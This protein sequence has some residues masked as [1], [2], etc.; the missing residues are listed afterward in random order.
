MKRGYWLALTA[1]VLILG[2]AGYRCSTE[3]VCELQAVSDAIRD[4][5][6][7]YFIDSSGDRT[8]LFMTDEKGTIYGQIEAPRLQGDW[9]N[10]YGS[11]VKDLDGQ[12]YV[13]CYS[14]SLT[15]LSVHSVVYRCDFENSALVPVYTLPDQRFYQIQVIDGW[16]YYFGEVG[17]GEGTWGICRMS[18]EGSQELFMEFE[19]DVSSVR[20]SFCHPDKGTVWTDSSSRFYYDGRDVTP[21]GKRDYVN[22]QVD[23][24]GICYTDV[25]EGTVKRVSFEDLHPEILFYTED[26]RLIEGG[27]D[28]MDIVPFRYYED[29]SWTGGVDITPERRVLGVFEK[30]G[31]Q[32]LQISR[33]ILSPAESFAL[34][35]NTLCICLAALM[36]LAGATK[37]GLWLTKG[38][39]PVIF[40]LLLFLIPL[41]IITSL[42]L[43][44]RISHFV[45]ERMLR[46]QYGLLY[47]SVEWILN[48]IDPEDLASIELQ[49]I[50]EDPYYKKVFLSE[51][52]YEPESGQAGVQGNIQSDLSNV[53]VWLL[54]KQEGALRYALTDENNYY[55]SRISYDRTREELEKME[56]AMDTGQIIQT[57]YNDLTG[58]FIALYVPVLDKEGKGIGIWECGLST[59]V[60][61]YEQAQQTARIHAMLNGSMAVLFFIMLVVLAFFIYPLIRLKAAV[62]SVSQGNL[63]LEVRVRGRDEV[64]GIGNA[65]NNMSRQ[66]KEHV[67]F[68]QACLEGYA[69]F[70]PEKV[71]E[72]LERKDIT[73]VRLGDQK[74]I[75]GAVLNLGSVQFEENARTMGGDELY[76]LINQMLK[77]MIPAVAEN[78]GI[79]ERMEEDGLNAYYPEACEPALNSAI[80]I[81]QRFRTLRTEGHRMPVYRANI[82]YGRLR[83]GIVGSRERMA[84]AV[85][86]DLIGITSF[87]KKMGETYGV[88][89]LVLESAAAQIPDFKKRFHVR[90]IGTLYR[91]RTGEA[92]YVYDVYNGDEAEDFRAKEKTKTKFEKAMAAYR[93]GRYYD[94]RL[95]FAKILKE[96]GRDLAAREYVYR[97]D[98]YCQLGEKAAVRIHLEEY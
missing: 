27:L 98:Q 83:L 86:S 2:I 73:E 63:G 49:N 51:D 11:L 60:L 89:I 15:E 72:L 4:G 75:L 52:Y 30:D 57:K 16:V 90:E 65:F 87:L 17:E 84:A 71:F 70:V 32:R 29:G 79:V 33:V 68:I 5:D 12:V 46:T 67:E 42:V 55:G 6:K 96:N 64:A 69:A 95:L 20:N 36:A 88:K 38:T 3:R 59:R 91:R 47:G 28:Y 44:R 23:A 1:A 18:P 74:E 62:E 31:V 8:R 66:L 85:S 22:I 25:K 45:E 35:L 58:D 82:S 9:W 92:E 48:G 53:Y 40:Q 81:C 34:W 93:K 10:I 78:Q 94:A 41:I 97:C 50:P 21:E 56:Q 80:L 54:L 14:R 76:P 77:E 37:L 61:V 39:V 24:A 7:L 43:E 19:G 13:Y 26:V